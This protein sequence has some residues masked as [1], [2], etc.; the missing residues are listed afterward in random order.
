MIV[1]SQKRCVV[2]EKMRKNLSVFASFPV[3]V[4]KYSDKSNLRE[5][6]FILAHGCK[7][8]VHHGG[9]VKTAGARMHAGN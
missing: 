2:Q 4:I 1:D 9:E 3:A 6:E 5:K 8:T 7:G